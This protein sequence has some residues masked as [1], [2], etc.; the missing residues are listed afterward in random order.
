MCACMYICVI[1]YYMTDSICST[2]QVSIMQMSFQVPSYF[3]I[4]NR[5][6][7]KYDFLVFTSRWQKEEK[8]TPEREGVLIRREWFT[9]GCGWGTGWMSQT[10]C[11]TTVED[12]PTRTRGR[13][14][15]GQENYLQVCEG[16]QPSR[17]SR[18]TQRLGTGSPEVKA[19]SD[20]VR[21]KGHVPLSS[22]LHG[23]R[24]WAL[25]VSFQTL[26]S[27]PKPAFPSGMLMKPLALFAPFPA[28]YPSR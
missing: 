18:L 15:G 27:F 16:C 23:P 1:P 13:G 14:L 7:R 22:L 24:L 5:Q 25:I 11:M 8:A 2:Q 26:G 20:A 9:G 28:P 19:S 12:S 10:P 6:V 17:R 21:K 4:G 3:Q